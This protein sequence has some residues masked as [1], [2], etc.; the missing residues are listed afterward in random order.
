MS[1]LQK[2]HAYA[3]QC[4][5]CRPAVLLH[6]FGESLVQPCQACDVCVA[7]AKQRVWHDVTSEVVESLAAAAKGCEHSEAWGYSKCRKQRATGVHAAADDGGC[8]ARNAAGASACTLESSK[9]ASGMGEGQ[10]SHLF[11]RGRTVLFILS[12][13]CR[14]APRSSQV[15]RHPRTDAQP[16]RAWPRAPLIACIVQPLDAAFHRRQLDINWRFSALSPIFAPYSA[17]LP[18]AD[19]FRLQLRVT[20]KRAGCRGSCVHGV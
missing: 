5:T 9:N 6:Y 15:T 10:R 16:R 13:V 1:S 20:A 18:R 17:H 7:G 4:V 12:R 2:L 14:S 19:Y 8:A 11:W 3:V